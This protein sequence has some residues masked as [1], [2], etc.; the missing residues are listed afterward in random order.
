MTAG[1]DTCEHLN[2]ATHQMGW[3][4]MMGGWITF[5]YIKDNLAL[6]VKCVQKSKTFTKGFKCTVCEANVNI[7]NM[8]FS[9][10]PY[11]ETSVKFRIIIKY[12]QN[13]TNNILSQS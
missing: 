12:K 6:N 8:I 5:L 9:K 10:F 11:V 13:Q 1:S 2:T 4:D 3:M 7:C